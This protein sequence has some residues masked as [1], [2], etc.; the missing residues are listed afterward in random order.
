MFVKKDSNTCFLI[1]SLY[2][3]DLIFTG[4]SAIIKIELKKSMKVEFDMKDLGKKTYFL[5]VEAV[6][7]KGGIFISQTKYAKEVLERF[8]YIF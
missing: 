5:G 8:L 6:Q 3:D 2:A 4:N 1:V 7:S